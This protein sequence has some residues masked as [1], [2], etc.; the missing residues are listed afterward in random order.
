MSNGSYLQAIPWQD[1]RAEIKQACAEVA[2]LI[3]ALDPAKK[4]PLIKAR[5][6]FGDKIVENGLLNLPTE[7]GQLLPITDSRIPDFA[8][9]VLDY[10]PVPLGILTNHSIEVFREL[11][12]RIFSIDYHGKGF[13]IGIWEYFDWTTPYSLTAGARVPNDVAAYHPNQC[14]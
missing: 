2:S 10:S 3:D 4:Y 8:R 11:D 1:A 9:K 7:S 14:A 6:N 5:Y 13:D 12:D